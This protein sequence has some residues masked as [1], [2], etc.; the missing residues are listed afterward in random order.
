MGSFLMLAMMGLSMAFWSS[1]RVLVHSFFYI[2]HK[3][4]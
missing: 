2:T 4:H 3:S 1:T